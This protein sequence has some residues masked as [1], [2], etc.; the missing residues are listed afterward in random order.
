MAT[1]LT[2]ARRGNH[3]INI[4]LHHAVLRAGGAARGRSGS[5]YPFKRGTSLTAL[6]LMVSRDSVYDLFCSGEL[7]GRKV[8]RRWITIKAA[9]LRWIERTSSDDTLARAIKKG[10]GQALSDALNSGKARIKLKGRMGFCISP[11]K[12]LS[13]SRKPGALSRLMGLAVSGTCARSSSR[14]YIQ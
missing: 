5:D 11:Q 1:A 8:G 4:F 3:H 6:L 10:K 7:S 12:P 14:Y 13:A 9:V 2:P